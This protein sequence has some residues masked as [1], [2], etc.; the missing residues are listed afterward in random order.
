MIVDFGFVVSILAILLSLYAL[1]LAKKA[2]KQL[3]VLEQLLAEFEE[4][5]GAEAPG[6]EAW[7][8]DVM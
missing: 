8:K 1:V 7:R 6:R 2:E 4:A 5:R 3:A